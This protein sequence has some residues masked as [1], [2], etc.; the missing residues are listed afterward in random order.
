M[1]IVGD[2]PGNRSRMTISLDDHVR[3]TYPRRTIVRSVGLDRPLGPATA[4]ATFDHAADVEAWLEELQHG[5][6]AAAV[7]LARFC[8]EDTP[9]GDEAPGV[10]RDATGWLAS[11]ALLGAVIG[12]LAAA[13]VLALITTAITSSGTVVL[14]AAVAGLVIGGIAG[15]YVAILGR[16]GST[17]SE[18]EPHRMEDPSVGVVA[19]PTDSYDRALIAGEFLDHSGAQEVSIVDS[20]GHLVRQVKRRA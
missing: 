3:R 1:R 2:R 19:V 12:G 9:L 11:H 20:D 17:E 14:A 10:R 5:H 16:F 7:S 18:K 15:A 13:L 6:A 8:E 4:V